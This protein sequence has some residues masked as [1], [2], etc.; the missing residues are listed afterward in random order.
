MT[1][2]LRVAGCAGLGFLMWKG[3][4]QSYSALL[5]KKDVRMW[6]IKSA[7]KGSTTGSKRDEK[8]VSE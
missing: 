1:F 4:K 6:E 8:A 7:S 2:L 5:R 3:S